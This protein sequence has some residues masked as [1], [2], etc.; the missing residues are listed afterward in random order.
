[1]RIIQ[2][3]WSQNQAQLDLYNRGGWLSNKAYLWCWCLSCLNAKKLYGNIELYTDQAGYE[4]LINKL[5]LPYDKVHIVFDN[6]DFEQLPISLWSLSKIYT[7]S[8]QNEPYVHIDGDFI[9]WN[10]IDFNKDVIF[11]NLEVDIALYSDI[12]NIIKRNKNYFKPSYFLDCIY[13]DLGCAANLGLVGGRNAN[14]I[15]KYA[16]QVQSFI[17]DNIDIINNLFPLKKDFNCFIEQYYFMY[18]V[19]KE[20]IKY[21]VIHPEIFPHKTKDRFYDRVDQFYAFNHFLGFAKKNELVNDFVGRKLFEHYP[22]YY[23]KV[24]SILKDYHSY[25]Y[26]LFHRNNTINIDQF[27]KVFLNKIKD[28]NLTIEDKLLDDFG[29]FWKIK[30][31][32]LS[33][34]KDHPKAISRF[35]PIVKNIFSDYND[36]ALHFKYSNNFLKIDKFYMDW[37]TILLSEVYHVTDDKTKR[38]GIISIGE[39][40]LKSRYYIFFRTQ[41]ENIICSL[42]ISNIQAFLFNNILKEDFKS[43]KSIIEDTMNLLSIKKEDSYRRLKAVLIEVLCGTCHLGI[44]EIKKYK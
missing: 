4:L 7:Y 6:E 38:K 25:E 37:D 42:S 27:E 11:Q 26:Y 16:K 43:L 36:N 21:D 44:T 28:V 34:D 29:R 22:S 14:F 32:L 20:Q 3:Y 24:I 39:N 17:K 10:K 1:M 8:L 40:E 19:N 41:F 13:D 33:H 5:N 15:K 18:L 35:T 2:T 9:L 12:Y 31:E 23:H 30:S